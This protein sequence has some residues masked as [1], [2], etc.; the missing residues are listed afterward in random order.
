M[1][2]TIMTIAYGGSNAP[3]IGPWPCF[4]DAER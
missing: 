1:V 4:P 2:L 3:Q